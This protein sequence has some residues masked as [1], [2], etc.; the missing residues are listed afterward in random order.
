[1]LPFFFYRYVVLEGSII[2]LHVEL[3]QKKTQLVTGK[4]IGIIYSVAHLFFLQV[5]SFQGIYKH[6]ED[7]IY[8]INLMLC[9]WPL[10]LLQVFIHGLLRFSKGLSHL[11]G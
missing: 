2:I 8:C 4:C 7:R 5:N 10:F 9:S 3:M 1:M 6:C 11:L